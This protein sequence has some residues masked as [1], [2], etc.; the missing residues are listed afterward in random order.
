MGEKA[1]GMNKK[2]GLQ[3]K[4]L[5]LFLLFT[6]IP[7]VLVASVNTFLSVKAQKE[8]AFESNQ[9]VASRLASEIGLFVE[10]SRGLTETLAATSSAR[11]LDAVTLKEV[12]LAAQK[13]NP[14]FEL[15]YVMNA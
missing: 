14:Q 9:L 4:F 10:Q 1:L 8:D 13:A 2:K 7:A 11:Q 6:L 15:I 3:K 12:I 5:W